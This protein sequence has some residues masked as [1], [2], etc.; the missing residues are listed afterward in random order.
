MHKKPA[1]TRSAG[2]YDGGAHLFL[3]NLHGIPTLHLDSRPYQFL[4]KVPSPNV[5][6]ELLRRGLVGGY[7]AVPVASWDPST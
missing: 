3:L 6:A 7:L 5:F 2:F 4:S 1:K